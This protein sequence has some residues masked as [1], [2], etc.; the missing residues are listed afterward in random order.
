VSNQ[1]TTNK[2]LVTSAV[3][4]RI[5]NELIRAGQL[6]EESDWQQADL[7]KE[8][9]YEE[10]N[11]HQVQRDYPKKNYLLHEEEEEGYPT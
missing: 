1:T 2:E 6:R 11:Q 10:G 7:E 5:T 8:E 3:E 9:L 4:K